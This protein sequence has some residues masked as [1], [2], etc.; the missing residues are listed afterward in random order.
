MCVTSACLGLT[1]TLEAR[2]YTKAHI[3]KDNRA[4]VP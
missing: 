2:R 1:D 4:E 3:P